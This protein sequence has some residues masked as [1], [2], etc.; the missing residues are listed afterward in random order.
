[1]TKV[2]AT[3]MG[4]SPLFAGID[5]GDATA[6]LDVV[7]VSLK[8]YQ[9]NEVVLAMA[10]VPS[11]RASCGLVVSGCLTE[12]VYDELANR[13]ALNYYYPGDLFGAA[14]QIGNVH[15]SPSE[16]GAMRDAVVLFLDIRPENL[17]RLDLP[18]YQT[19]TT[20]LIHIITGRVIYLKMRTHILSQKHVSD[21]VRLFLKMAPKDAD[22]II[23][24]PYTKTELADYL[25]VD[26]AVLQRE[27]TKLRRANIIKVVKNEISVLDP[28]YLE[29]A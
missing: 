3:A 13:L 18:L 17:V 11:A 22:R 2:L 5:A 9:K 7:G 16:F 15:R 14:L 27:L 10:D 24:L 19:M 23:H 4:S 20:N 8:H 1:M 29:T 26:R 25:Y 6:V 28:A 12:S 21:R